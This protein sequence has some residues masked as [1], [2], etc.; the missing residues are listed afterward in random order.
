MVDGRH[1][2]RRCQSIIAPTRLIGAAV[3]ILSITVH[4]YNI[5]CGAHEC[6]N[7]CFLRADLRRGAHLRRPACSVQPCTLANTS[8]SRSQTCV[9]EICHA[10]CL[11]HNVTHVLLE[12][13]LL[14]QCPLQVMLRRMRFSAMCFSAPSDPSYIRSLGHV[15]L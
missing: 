11:R 4:D 7:S 9:S 3:G 6:K 1:L 10:P 14:P 8:T 13:R 15:I 12:N 5:A 2:S